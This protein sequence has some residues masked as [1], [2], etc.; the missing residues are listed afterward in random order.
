[1]GVELAESGHDGSVGD[2]FHVDRIH[3]V[4]LNLLKDQ[5]E[6]APILV[7]G[8]VTASL[9]D[10]VQCK[11]KQRSNGNAKERHPD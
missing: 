10:S 4:V 6:L 2:L 8:F 5:V 1:M 7:G 9:A 3:I 11:D